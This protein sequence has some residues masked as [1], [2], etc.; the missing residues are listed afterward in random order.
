LNGAPF[1]NL[2]ALR[3]IE[4]EGLNN[5]NVLNS[6]IMSAKGLLNV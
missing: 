2:T 4:G 5:L 6:K 1:E 3:K